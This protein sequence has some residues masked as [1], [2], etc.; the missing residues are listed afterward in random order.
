MD[1]QTEYKK[2]NKAQ[3]EA[4]DAIEGP[5]MVVAGPGTGKTQILTLR[6]AN[7]L[8]KTQT[9]PGN[10]LALT[11]T[12]AGA[13]EMKRRLR[14][15][16]GSEAE[17][18]RIHTYHGFARS[19]IDEF[20]DHFPHLSRVKQITEIEKEAL[21]REILKEKKFSKLRPPGEPDFFVAKII[22]AISDAKQEAWMP[23]MVRSFATEE[24]ERIKQD[25]DSLST[26]G[27]TK[28]KLKADALK[29][30]EKCERTIIFSGL[31]EA[32]ENGKKE[33]R[34]MD[35]DDLII[36]L[37]VALRTDEL[38]LRMLQE[39]FL[40]ILIDEHQ[41]TNDAQNLFI[42]MIADFFE[43]PNLFVVGDEKQAIY[44]FQGASVENFLQFQNIWKSMKVIPLEINYR[45]HQGILDAG[46]SMIENNYGEGEYA[47]LRIKLRSGGTQPFRQLTLITPGNVA[48]GDKYLIE[49]LKSVLGDNPAKTIAIITRRN[50][51][52]EH[53]L[54][55]LQKHD[56]SAV[57]ERGI[58]I[59]SHPLGQLFFAL[60]EF[61][62]D[63][64]QIEALAQTIAA[65]LWNLDFEKQ[66]KYIKK[67]RSGTIGD[68]SKEIP[69][70]MKLK[71][72]VSR[73]GAISYLAFAGELSGVTGLAS[74]DPF[75]AEVWRAIIGLAS[76]LASQ[77]SADDPAKLMKDLL[78]YRTSA[79][80]KSVKISVG[81]SDAR[82]KLM[83][84]HGSKGLEF[85]YV[86]IPYATEESWIAKGRGV[87]F[88]L[89]KEKEQGD[90]IRDIR[91]LFY[92]ALTRARSHVYL[93]APL[94]ERPDRPLSPLRF[95]SELGQKHIE[96]IDL[97]AIAE[98]SVGESLAALESRQA[99]EITAYAK[100][101]LLEHGLSVTALNHF[102]DCPMEFLYK[103]IL[104]LPEPPAGNAE[105]G[106]AMH[107]AL[108]R[109]WHLKD[110]TEK[111]ITATITRTVHEYFEDSLL[112]LFEKEPIIEELSVS[113]PIV[114][115]ALKNHFQQEGTIATETSVEQMFNGTYKNKAIPLTLRGKLDAVLET[116]TMVSVFDYKTREALSVNAIKGQTK[117][118]DG[119]YFRQLIFYKIL[120]DKKPKYK[121]K[122]IEP[123]LVFIK[124]DDKGRCP[125]VALPVEEADMERVKKEIQKLIDSIWSGKFLNDT[126]DD[127]DCQYCGLRKMII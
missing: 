61:L 93:I 31:Y 95:L 105:K 30:I 98:E 58:D 107:E 36:E 8:K 6:I 69:A 67:I 124:P 119:N 18:V 77:G 106:N 97:P 19:I 9:N 55:L 74:R 72:E 64:A 117:D 15:I 79:E 51:E 103:S 11:F 78:D 94:E 17:D 82:V 28:G 44:R 101:L 99:D 3:K 32:Y 25:E 108:A 50:K 121:N 40:Y 16:I 71:K 102:C 127:K 68:L 43:T 91:R 89:P 22:G 23:D 24:I 122:S 42:R 76:E 53:L 75:S 35:F 57:A 114:A 29:R 41:D 54:A 84:A 109:V 87:Y 116:K 92:V 2:L 59:F 56:I 21:V 90:E 111:N 115:S 52:I 48:A 38:L 70:I 85:D 113:A 20:D 66:T 96:K 45:S 47:N 88:I 37:L 118:S 4:V 46:F 83:T 112:P 65:G 5:V 39:R 33:D 104:K 7:I 49:E 27:P 81:A 34:K 110:K 60:I 86:F 14:E 120:L 10:I 1:F 26:R 126:C 80:T 125:I 62:L 73:H 12:E 13:K 63:P 123:A 100:Q